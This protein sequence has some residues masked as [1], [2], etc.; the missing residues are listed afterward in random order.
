M[1]IGLMNFAGIQP[2]G[3]PLARQLVPGLQNAMMFPQQLQQQ[4]LAQALT[5]AQ[6]AQSGAHTNLLN[7]QSK[8]LPLKELIAATNAQRL[9]SRFGQA[10]Q[11]QSALNSLDPSTRNLWISQHP[12]EYNQHLINMANQASSGSQNQNGYL[13]KAIQNLFPG[14]KVDSPN[15]MN[16]Q[17]NLP[18]NNSDQTNNQY[19]DSNA[20]QNNPPGNFS[21]KPVDVEELQTSLEHQSN[22]KGA[23]P[24]INRRAD[25]AVAL[26]DWLNK[27]KE[28]YGDAF[29]N[30]TKYSQ[31]LGKGEKGIDALSKNSPQAY[32]DYKWVETS[33]IPH[34][35]NQVKMMEQLA[36][37]DKQRS[38][39]KELAGALD[40]F[41]L[42]PVS[43]LK[44]FNRQIGT[45]QDIS[46][47]VFAA[48]EP[49]KKGTYRKSFKIPRE[50]GDYVN[51]VKN[52]KSTNY[53]RV[54]GK[55]MRVE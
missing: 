34:L 6:T 30:V 21:T 53:K 28:K 10:Y 9:G 19:N 2:Q 42:D 50:T 12:K 44:V 4:Q 16:Y 5:K 48:A 41:T 14:Y 18:Q 25:A 38:E 26:E 24:V 31:F 23:G 8:Y 55:L 51:S 36:A 7:Q 43:S 45:I 52:K 49:N 22:R 37:T 1:P 17:N 11:L 27:N 29:R 35:A 46:D 32:Q 39:L 20:Q 13:E 15:Q 33:F 3:N 54:N 47:S 40:S